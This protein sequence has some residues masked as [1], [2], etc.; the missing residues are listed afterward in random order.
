MTHE[1]RFAMNSQTTF[2]ELEKTS[3]ADLSGDQW[4]D[5]YPNL[6]PWLRHAS[7]DI[8]KRAINRLC[9]A[10]FWAEPQSHG[11]TRLRGELVAEKETE[12]I[13]WLLNTVEA[14]HAVHQDI[15]PLA[16]E[17]MRFQNDDQP[18][19]P[20][21]RWLERLRASPPL[22][23]DPGTV[24]GTILLQQSFDEDDAA[25]V[26]S[27]VALLDHPANYVRACAARKMSCL[28]GDALN[29]TEMFALIK[30][31]EI[32]RPG[33]AGPYWTEWGFC[34]E[35]VP[36]D[37]IEWMMDILERRSGPEPLD[38]PF[39][40]IDFHLHEVCDYSPQTVLRMIKGGHIEIAIQ[41]AT[42]THGVVE[43]M[44]PV[45]RQLADHIDSATRFSAQRHLANYYRFLH[46]EAAGGTIQHWPDWSPDA[47]VFS[48]HS[49]QNSAL[50]YIVIYPRDTDGTLTD[51]A[52]WL[53][54]DKA[55]PP[56]LRGET[57][58]HHF[59][60]NKEPPP[61]P[62]QLGDQTMW[63]FASGANLSLRGNP[64]TKHW[65]RIE[66]MGA[67]LGARWNPFAT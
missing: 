29:A 48:F 49:G 62:Y 54:I 37:P 14:A 53:L 7:A 23:V 36:I 51:S 57:V 56:S 35:H 8:R 60:Y 42:E 22:G 59:D 30:E 45:L 15:I 12:R 38:I 47:D 6:T 55:L 17:Q 2:Y 1:Y 3:L 13:S 63:S 25:D 20:V 11:P 58:F 21:T 41:T 5:Y 67:H 26:A 52:A 40:G 19:H 39:N 34:R 65:T 16:L 33:I 61:G 64:D 32:I 10:V 24:E 44:E 31:K 28:E 46:P 43:G 18:D 27:L 50:W 4:D 9:T 66:I